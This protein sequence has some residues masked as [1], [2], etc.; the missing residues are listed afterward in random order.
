M[1]APARRAGAVAWPQFA[2][3][4][5]SKVIAA[6]TKFAAAIGSGPVGLDL[7]QAKSG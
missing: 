3:P 4:H 6:L 7:A 5:R 2:T 1:T